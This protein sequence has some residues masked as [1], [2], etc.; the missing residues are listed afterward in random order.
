MT[1]YLAAGTQSA[2]S[3]QNFILLLKMSQLHKTLRE[4]E[5][6]E[7]EQEEDEGEGEW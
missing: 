2:S 1:A 6:K 7:E 4:E 5:E 3:R